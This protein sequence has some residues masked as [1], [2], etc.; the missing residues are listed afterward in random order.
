MQSPKINQE[1]VGL[2]GSTAQQAIYLRDIKN[3]NIPICSLTEQTQIVAILESKLTACDQLAAELSK[4]LKQAE[5]LKQAVL[6]AAFQG[7]LSE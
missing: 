2:S 4:Q 5:L 3:I 6:T 7:E 1:M